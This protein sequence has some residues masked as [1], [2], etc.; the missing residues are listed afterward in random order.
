MTHKYKI[1]YK[2]KYKYTKIQ[3]HK[4]TNTSRE[5]KNTK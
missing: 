5:N 2:H 4:Q 3:L 1:T